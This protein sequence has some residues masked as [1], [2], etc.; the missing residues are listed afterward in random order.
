MKNQ[1]KREPKVKNKK[2][3][4]NYKGV[5]KRKNGWAC[6]VCCNYKKVHYSSH[7]TEIEAAK[8]YNKIAPLFHGKFA[9]L[10]VIKDGK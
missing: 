2:Y 4:S 10:N 3:T 8:M 7:E 9:K 6:T 1:K 5:Y